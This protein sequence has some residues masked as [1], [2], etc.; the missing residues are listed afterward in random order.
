MSNESMLSEK[1]SVF[2]RSIP[3]EV[4]LFGVLVILFIV[5]SFLTN[6]FFTGTN[7]T[8]LVRQASVNGIVALG[9]TFV[10]IS[11]GIDLS[12]GSVV[13]FSGVLIGMLM[14]NGVPVFFSLIISTI[15]SSLIGLANGIIIHDGKVPPFIATLGSMTVVR[16]GIMLISNARMVSGLPKSFTGFAQLRLAGL[17]TLFLVWVALIA[18]SVFITRKTVFGRNIYALGSNLEAA[19]LSGINIRITTYGVYLFCAFASAVAGILMTSRLGNGIPTGGQGYELDAIAATVV[20]GASLDGGEGTIIGTVF[21]AI[22]MAALRNGG[23]LL[24]VNPFILEIIIGG[25]IV[26]AV[27]IDKKR[28]K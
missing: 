6:R 5:L 17:P 15:I 18:V 11:A 9:M 16:G 7:L 13:G 22:I 12:V 23:N 25:L 28:K 3:T 24:G 19:R 27:L 20:G 1:K 10:I 8:N 2:N 14:V 21:G 26:V 4:F